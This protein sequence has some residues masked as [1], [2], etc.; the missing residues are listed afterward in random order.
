MKP[1]S[2]FLKHYPEMI[3]RF[4]PLVK[5]LRFEAKHSYF[6]GLS[7]ITSNRKNNCQT[8]A[9]RHQYTMYLHYSKR[10]LLEHKHIVGS[11][12][13]ESPLEGLDYDKKVLLLGNTNFQDIIIVCEMSSVSYESQY[14]DIGSVLVCDFVQDEFV[15][16]VIG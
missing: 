2:H 5:T 3:Q 6:K 11:K 14:Y 1:K 12:V 13:A 8:L 7:Q 16:G 15:F 4:G 10:D 9:K